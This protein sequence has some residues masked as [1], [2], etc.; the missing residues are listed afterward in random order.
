MTGLSSDVTP[1]M[2]ARVGELAPDFSLN[3][4]HGES[5]R[6]SDLRGQVVALLFYPQDETLVCT[7]QLCSLRD[8]WAEYV[9]TG[10][11]VV[12]VSN[13]SEASHRRFAEQHHLPLPLLADAGN[14]V[15]KMYSHHWWMPAWLTRAIVVIDAQ[16]IV[17][18]RQVMFRAFR[19]DDDDVITAIY[20]ARCERLS[21]FLK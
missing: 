21:R 19:P 5:W 13:G 12:G 4:A 15:T 2:R 11:T 8:R 17:L 6:L 9:T 14:H 7:R 3:N 20:S 16:G 18:T 1:P 10:A